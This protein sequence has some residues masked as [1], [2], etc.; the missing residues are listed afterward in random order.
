ML[1][2]RVGSPFLNGCRIL[3][4]AG[5]VSPIPTTEQIQLLLCPL[6]S[7]SVGHVVSPHRSTTAG[8]LIAVGP[9]QL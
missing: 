9:S 7:E 5:D 8:K 3:I 2:V 1:L 6:Y 4:P